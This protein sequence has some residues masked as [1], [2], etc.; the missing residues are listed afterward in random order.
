MPRPLRADDR[1]QVGEEL[2]V[3]RHVLEDIHAH[4]AVE[5]RDVG[6]HGLRERPLA[7]HD[8][9]HDVGRHGREP[10][11]TVAPGLVHPDHP[12]DAWESPRQPRHVLAPA[13]P[14]VEQAHGIAT[15]R[16]QPRVHEM[17]AH[18]RPRPQRRARQERR[19]APAPV[20]PAAG[21]RFRDR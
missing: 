21:H 9:R 15:E 17:P 19:H 13:A 8:P 2:A 5:R 20:R 16:A 1:R 7:Q 3:V 11:D 18:D 4:H 12:A 14:G 10:R 6:H